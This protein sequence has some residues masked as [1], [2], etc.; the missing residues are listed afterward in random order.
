MSLLGQNGA[1]DDVAVD[2]AGSSIGHETRPRQH[3]HIRRQQLLRSACVLVPTIGVSLLALGTG[4]R[5]VCA[6]CASL[7]ST[8]LYVA[9]YDPPLSQHTDEDT[10]T[11]SCPTDSDTSDAV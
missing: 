10:D 11:V 4:W 3:V 9:N 2:S 7:V 5:D 6:F 8:V 1:E